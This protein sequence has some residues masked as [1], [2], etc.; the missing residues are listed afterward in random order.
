MLA[1]AVRNTAQLEPERARRRPRKI[2][3]QGAADQVCPA[4]LEPCLMDDL[5]Q[6]N[7]PR[8]S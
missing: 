3:G 7:A 5:D 4:L 8:L 6:D 1:E 2:S